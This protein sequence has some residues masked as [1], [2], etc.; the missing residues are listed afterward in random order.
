MGNISQ[1]G[2]MHFNLTKWQNSTV[3]KKQVGGRPCGLEEEHSHG[4]WA[5]RFRILSILFLE[6]I[7][8]D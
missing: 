2:T 3:T 1:I 6:I 4:A 7:K 5:T 8:K